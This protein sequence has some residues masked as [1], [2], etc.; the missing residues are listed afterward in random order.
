MLVLNR[1][2]GEKIRIGKDIVVVLIQ[3]G[4]N[5]KIGIDAPKDVP[6]IREEIIH[7]SDEQRVDRGLP[8]R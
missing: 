5:V 3:A 2:A 1:K 6:V 7:D 8:C 4:K